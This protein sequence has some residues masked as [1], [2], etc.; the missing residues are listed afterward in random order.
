M[1]NTYG[2][3]VDYLLTVGSKTC[4]RLSTYIARYL[5]TIASYSVQRRFIPSVTPSFPPYISPAKTILSPLA[6]YIFYPVSTAPTN[7]N[8][9]MKFK[10][11]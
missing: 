3:L 11:R 6:E 10:E 5:Q 8:P 7:S 4:A 1:H 9:L 2:K